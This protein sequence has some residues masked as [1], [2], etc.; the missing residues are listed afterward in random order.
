MKAFAKWKDITWLHELNSAN[1]GVVSGVMGRGIA[2]KRLRG[3]GSAGAW[4]RNMGIKAG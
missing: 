1:P 3:R 4:L 2:G